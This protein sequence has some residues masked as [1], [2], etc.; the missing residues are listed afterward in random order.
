MSILLSA[1]VFLG[2]NGPFGAIGEQ[3]LKQIG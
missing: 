2:A 1:H 3:L